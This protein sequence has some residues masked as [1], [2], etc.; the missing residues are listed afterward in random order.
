MGRAQQDE[1]ARLLERVRQWDSEAWTALYQR[2][3]PEL[4]RFAARQLG[5]AGL[6]EEC[7]AETFARFLYALR[8]GGGP[9]QHVRAYLYRIAQNWIND[10][11]R[12]N[13]RRAPAAE[14]AERAAHLAGGPRPEDWF[15]DQEQTARL[16]QALALLPDAH[17][18]V[19]VLRFVEQ[20]PH[21][22]VAR[23]MGRS[24][25]AVKVLQHRALANLRRTFERLERDGRA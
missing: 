25:A 8:N 1:D 17:R 16:R 23:I 4:Y 5:D 10:H 9:R 19:L 7:V 12:Q 20:L 22:E 6:A 11:Y 15:T 3:S 13:R 24:V 2:Y 18:T 21:A 14:D